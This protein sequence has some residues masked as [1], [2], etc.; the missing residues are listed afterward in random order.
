MTANGTETADVV[1]IG[2]GAMGSAAAYFLMLLGGPG[3][4]VTVC[5][6]DPSYARSATLNAAGGIRQTFA[7]AENIA[8]SR[9]GSTFLREAAELLV[10]AGEGPDLSFRPVPY[11]YLASGVT[12][13]ER[14]HTC[15]Q[16][17][18]AAGVAGRLLDRHG[19]AALFPWLTTE[20]VDLGLLGG[21]QEGVFDPEALLR[22]LKHKAIALGA[23][24]RA[25]KVVGIE[26]EKYHVVAVKLETGQS[27]ACSQVVNAAGP[28]AAALAAMA[29]CQVPIVPRSA[30]TFLFRAEVPPAAAMPIIVD[31]VQKLHIRPEGDGFLASMPEA[32][33]LDGAE[34][35]HDLFDGLLWPA[36]AQRVPAFA[37]IRFAGAWAGTIDAS[38]FDGNPFIGAH[39]ALT[40]FVF[41]AG[42][43][44][45]GLQHA[46][47][48]GRAIAELIV[49]GEYRSI[50]LG[51]FGFG[52][53]T[54]GE[55]TTEYY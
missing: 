16:A 10:V 38:P 45:H 32:G 37:A 17:R 18:V 53:L 43:N 24:Y 5:E 34:I 50:D 19:L 11:L 52:R 26:V 25:A 44:G 41:L 12:E 33:G 30:T 1:V 54:N 3:L 31:R 28:G 42:F 13:V 36:L 55:R 27:I 2:G 46:P 40:N 9:Y 51:R 14:L 39:P 23:D 7:L 29:A 20:D 47:A 35:D 8:M 48:A 6:A 4:R 15:Q 49:H 22:A 21:G